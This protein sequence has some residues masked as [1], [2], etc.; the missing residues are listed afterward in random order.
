M[1]NKSCCCCWNKMWTSHKL[2]DTSSDVCVCLCVSKQLRDLWMW[3]WTLSYLSSTTVKAKHMAKTGHTL[4]PQSIHTQD[5]N[6]TC[7]RTKMQ[8]RAKSPTLTNRQLAVQQLSVYGNVL[9]VIDREYSWNHQQTLWYQLWTHTFQSHRKDFTCSIIN[10]KH[11]EIKVK[12]N[13]C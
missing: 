2:E 3:L 13:M 6:R 8:H 5:V 4:P 1:N 11:E 7:A 12:V 10:E 9:C